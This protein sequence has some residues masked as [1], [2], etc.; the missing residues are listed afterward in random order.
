MIICAAAASDL[1]GDGS[2]LRSKTMVW[3]GNIS[4]SFHLLQATVIFC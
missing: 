4:F 3:L 2:R 1:R